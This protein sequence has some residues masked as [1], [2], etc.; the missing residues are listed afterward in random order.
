MVI[1]T[2]RLTR[3]WP[4]ENQHMRSYGAIPYD[5][6]HPLD[7]VEGFLSL[8][9]ALEAFSGYICVE[10]GWAAA[11]IA[12]L[13][14]RRKPPPSDFPRR[15]QEREAHARYFERRETQ[16]A[17]PEWGLFLGPG[18]LARVTPD[19]AVFPVIRDVGRGKLCLLSDNPEDAL[20]AAFDVRLD[21]ARQALAPILMDVSEVP[22][23]G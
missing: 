16:I 18:H 8:A 13:G 7:I 14:M 23:D 5:P 9:T 4:I 22:V 10:S 21:A 12:A 19:P 11:E 3:N 15:A 6:A 20:T 1:F 17:G 2:G